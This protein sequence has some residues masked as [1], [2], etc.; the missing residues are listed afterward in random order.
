MNTFE[1]SLSVCKMRPDLAVPFACYWACTRSSRRYYPEGDTQLLGYLCGV[2]S[3][4]RWPNQAMWW[5]CHHKH[6]Q[7]GV[8]IHTVT[9]WGG[10][11]SGIVSASNGQFFRGSMRVFADQEQCG[12]VATYKTW[13]MSSRDSRNTALGPKRA[14]SWVR[15]WST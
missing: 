7:R 12:G 13:K 5:L 9:F 3:K 4:G 10:L 11:H 6:T 14:Y 1:A 8:P 2:S 15:R